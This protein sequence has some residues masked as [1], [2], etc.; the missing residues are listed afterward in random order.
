[1]QKKDRSPDLPALDLH[2]LHVFATSADLGSLSR[3][4]V[5][6]GIAQSAVSRHIAALEGALEGRLFHRTGRG[7]QLTELGEAMQ[8]RAQALLRDAQ[9]MMEE[10]RAAASTPRGT[11]GL[12]LVPSLSQ[13]VVGRLI[14]QLRERF[15]G[16]RLRVY[17]GYSGEIEEWVACGR[18]DVGVFNSY[19]SLGPGREALFSSEMLLVMAAND[20]L[21]ASGSVAFDELRKLPLVL[22]VRP[23][24]LRVLLDELGQR[25]GI[26]LNVELEADS[27]VAIKSAVIQGGMYSVLPPHAIAQ[28]RRFGMVE[29]IPVT[30]PSIRQATLIETTPH[31]PMTAAGREVWRALSMLLKRLGNGALSC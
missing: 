3:A 21:C 17:E 31:H 16:I 9:R 29:G 27:S 26:E 20:P 15:P 28:E 4:A 22:P 14:T 25:A 12:G 19:R 30:D 11:V 5:S 2:A 7:V 10:A 6:L 23:N 18:V 24:G 13:P 8:P 1:M